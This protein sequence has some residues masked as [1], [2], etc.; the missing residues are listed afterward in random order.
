M[1]EIS[2]LENF[3]SF[4]EVTDLLSS[5]N[6]IIL[7]NDGKQNISCLFARTGFIF[8]FLSILIHGESV[9][10]VEFYSKNVSQTQIKENFIRTYPL[11]SQ[12]VFHISYFN[13]V[14]EEEKLKQVQPESK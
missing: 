4:E 5:L 11:L 1:G 10:N 7:K 3:Q 6:N 8:N 14:K 12:K 9:V 2:N 13:A